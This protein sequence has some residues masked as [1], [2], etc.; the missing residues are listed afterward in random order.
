MLLFRFKFLIWIRNRERERRRG[1]GRQWDRQRQRQIKKEK[2]FLNYLW[3]NEDIFSY[4]N[5]NPIICNVVVVVAISVCLFVCVCVGVCVSV[6]VYERERER[7]E[8]SLFILRLPM[9][10]FSLKSYFHICCCIFL[11]LVRVCGIF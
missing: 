6:C 1:R 5:H 4:S 2:F 10:D 7:G 3:K 9:N 11:P 8:T